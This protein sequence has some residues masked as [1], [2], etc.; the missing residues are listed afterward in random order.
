M[1]KV[2]ILAA[3]FV[4][5]GGLLFAGPIEWGGSF[6]FRVGANP[7]NM[8]FEHTIPEDFADMSADIEA[9]IDD[10]NLLHTSIGGVSGGEVTIGDAYL[11]TEWGFMTTKLGNTAYDSPG[12]GVS[13]KDY[14]TKTKAAGGAGYVIDVPLGNFTISGGQFFSDPCMFSVGAKYSNGVVDTASIYYS[15]DVQANGG[16]KYARMAH[17]V[18]G[19]TKLV[20]GDFSTGAGIRVDDKIWAYGAG[21]KYAFAPSWVAVG[22]GVEDG[23]ASYG[24]DTG[25]AF[26]VWG[27]DVAVSYVEEFNEANLSAWYKPGVVKFKT[28][29]DWNADIP[30][31]IFF[32]VSADF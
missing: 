20:F 9:Q 5:A 3:L 2:L 16:G 30:D 24:A 4:F 29:Y 21:I 8:R 10:A 19:G 28:G 17:A 18:A 14:E 7:R 15:G 13:S 12:Y 11:Q 26:D 31:E 1:K 23:A 6:T 22:V 27:A 32:E 25:L